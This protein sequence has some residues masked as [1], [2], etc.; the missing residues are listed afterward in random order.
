MRGPGLVLACTCTTAT[1]FVFGPAVVWVIRVQNPHFFVFS[2]LR[3]HVGHL[4]NRALPNA[5]ALPSGCE[6]DVPATH[7][8]LGQHVLRPGGQG[9]D[10]EEGGRSVLD[11]VFG[12]QPLLSGP[13]GMQRVVRDNPYD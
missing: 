13:E 7:R 2:L 1:C 3:K 4:R 12:L 6:C 10:Q 9:G 8:V 5:P 11:D